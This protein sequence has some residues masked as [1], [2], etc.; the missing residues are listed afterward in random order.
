MTTRK[1]KH[2]RRTSTTDDVRGTNL[3]MV[4]GRVRVDPVLRAAPNEEVLL[5]FDLVSGTGTERRT[6]PVSWQGRAARVPRV[7]V[8]DEIMVLGTVQ[9]R[10]FRTGGVTANTV[11]VRAERVARTPAARRKVMSEAIG[12]LGS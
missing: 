1:I 11:D 5:T 12:H 3:V 10:F 8:D 2:V 7:A 9:R 4:V 6:V